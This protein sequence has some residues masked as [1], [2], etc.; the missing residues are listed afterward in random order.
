MQTLRPYQAAAVDRAQAA[1]RALIVAPPGAGK[2]TIAAE[3]IRREID[4][5]RPSHQCPPRYVLVLAHRK[6]LI[7]QAAHRIKTNTGIEPVI[8]QA[9]QVAGGFGRVIVASVQTLARRAAWLR[10]RADVISLVIIDEA[11]RAPAKSYQKIL[12]RL[13]APRVIGLTASPYRLDGKPLGDLFD[14]MIIAAEPADLIAA[15]QAERDE[16]EA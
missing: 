15:G 10:R 14:E 3:I 11:H 4:K 12:D 6:E 8:I 13:N 1:R 5:P 7:A 16:E 2:T 9:G